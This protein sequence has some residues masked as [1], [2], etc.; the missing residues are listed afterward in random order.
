MT[1]APP[2]EWW[3]DAVVYEVYPASF[4]DGDGDGMGDLLGLRERLPYIAA[5]GVDAIWITPWYPSPMA[6]GG[7][8]VSDYRG[9]QPTF[10]SLGDA[11][12]VI[13]EAHDLGL[14]V[15]IDMVAN[16]TSEQHPWFQAALKSRPGSPERARYLFAEGRGAD[17]DRPPNNWISAFGGPAWTRIDEPDG[18]PGQWYLHT[19]AREQ[20]DLN[21][22]DESVRRDFDD[23][24]RFWFDRGIDG[25]RVDAA[26]AFA[27]DPGF[28]DFAYPDDRAFRPLT[29]IDSPHWDVEAVHDILR[30]WRAV[31]DSYPEPR[32]FVAEA[33]VNGADRFARYLRP[34]EMHAAFNLAFLQAPWDA[35]LRHVIDET[36]AALAPVG[37]S[38]TWVLESHDEVRRITRFARQRASQGNRGQVS[39]S[40]LARGIQRARAATL[41]LLALPGSAYIYQGEELGLPEVL[42]LPDEYKK[43]PAWVRSGFTMHPREGCRVPLPWD[44]D[45]PPFGFTEDGVATWLPQPVQWRHLTVA[46]QEA[47]PDS[48][49]QLYRRALE[50]RRSLPSL[51][52]DRLTWV[53]APPDVLAFDRPGLRCILNLSDQPTSLPVGRMMLTSQG[54]VDECLPP[55]AAAWLRTD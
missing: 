17:G 34:D 39:E 33:G 14:R 5:L 51:R 20:P 50:L 4:A 13:A 10:G 55:D 35:G 7:Y 25:L 40:D 12:A 45:R 27:K 6:D 43:D 26:P 1:A 11:D 49:L 8:D 46:A 38:A 30:R 21:W 16:H 48:M 19:F 2:R 3:R 32:Y 22:A 9:I 23:I 29:W 53:D 41:V 36:L 37:A 18:R 28:A 24:L 44:G 15:I 47:A 52:S 54:L 31:G 42:D